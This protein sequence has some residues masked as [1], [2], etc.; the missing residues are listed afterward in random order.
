MRRLINQ[1]G[2]AD[3]IHVD[4]AGTHDYH[5]GA[6]PDPRAVKA[7]RRRGYDLDGLRARQVIAADFECFDQILAMDFNNIE[8]LQSLCPPEHRGKIGLLMPYACRRRALIVHDPYYR[9][10]KEFDIVLDYIEDACEGL[11]AT[12]MAKVRAAPLETGAAGLIANALHKH[13]AASKRVA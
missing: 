1:A 3:W 5:C 9:S 7:A 12:L 8:R 2:L 4:S 13:A 10:S 6:S 11:L